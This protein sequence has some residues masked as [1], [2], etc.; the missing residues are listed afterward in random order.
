MKNTRGQEN[1]QKKITIEIPAAKSHGYAICGS[2]VRRDFVHAVFG[3]CHHARGF[4]CP[5]VDFLLF[6]ALVL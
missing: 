6:D 3:L 4:M 5:L 2:C 1:R